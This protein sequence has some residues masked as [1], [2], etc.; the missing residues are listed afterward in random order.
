MGHEN[1]SYAFTAVIESRS[2]ADDKRLLKDFTRAVDSIPGGFLDKT[3]PMRTA[4][5]GRTLELHGSLHVQSDARAA[6]LGE[7]LEANLREVEGVA[8]QLVVRPG[9]LRA[10]NRDDV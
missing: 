1:T 4:A 6:A 5:Y 8:D 9:L 10:V 7:E 2:K 3:A